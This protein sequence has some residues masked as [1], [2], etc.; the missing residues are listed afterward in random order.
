[1]T[2]R[3]LYMFS[4]AVLLC[5]A[6]CS[7]KP[8]ETMQSSEPATPRT[9]KAEAAQEKTMESVVNEYLSIKNALVASD[10]EGA[11]AGA[12][13]LLNVVDATKMPLLQQKTKE[14]AAV[15]NLDT[16]RTHFD[17]L[18]IALYEQVKQQLD[19][20]RVLYKQYCPMAFDNRGAYWLSANREI[21]NP[22]FGDKMLNCGRIEEEIGN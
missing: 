18:S 7:G 13:A 12:V 9:K 8:Q 5:L 15:D 16:L 17:S 10:A 1:M 20:N 21:K 11:K 4:L 6:A 14:M 2:M 22:Y 3:L 19:S